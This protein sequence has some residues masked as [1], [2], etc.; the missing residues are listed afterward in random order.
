MGISHISRTA[1]VRVVKFYMHVSYVKFQHNDD[2]SPLK[3]AWSDHVTCFLKILPNYI[4]IIGE[5]RL[6]K[7]RVLIHT[8]EYE[9]MQDILLPIGMC[10]ES[11]DLFKF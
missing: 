1:E 9:C 5:A 2:K 6:F 3:G 8:E 7:F 10:S 11:R 4:C